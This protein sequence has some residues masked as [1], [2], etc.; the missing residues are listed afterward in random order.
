MGRA[1]GLPLART[2]RSR[3]DG[4][5]SLCLKTLNPL[6][7]RA[8]H[9]ATCLRRLFRFQGAILTNACAVGYAVAAAGKPQ[10]SAR[11]YASS[12]SQIK[13]PEGCGSHTRVPEPRTLQRANDYLAFS[14]PTRR[15]WRKKLM[16]QS[17]G[18][19]PVP[20]WLWQRIVKLM[21]RHEEAYL[22]HCR[23]YIASTKNY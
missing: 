11:P 3:T 15:A 5:R 8:I 10:A 4:Q 2:S 19:A 7:L 18:I 12:A 16:H 6:T 9:R 13:V 21:P 1:S 14:I 20:S 17:D 22:E 23:Q